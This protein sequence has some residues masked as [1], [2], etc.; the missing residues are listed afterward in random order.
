MGPRRRLNGWAVKTVFGLVFLN[1]VLV[2][3]F[4]SKTS[5][6]EGRE[7]SPATYTP[8]QQES[9]RAIK[10]ILLAGQVSTWLETPEP[11]YNIAITL[12]MKLERMGYQV[13][14]N[15]EQ[16][17]DAALVIDY[18]ETAGRQYEMFQQGT[19]ITCTVTLHHKAVGKVLTRK[20]EAATTW[21]QPVGSLYWDAVQHL[22]ENPHYYYLGELIKGWLTAQEGEVVVF[23][24]MLK[25]PPLVISTEGGGS[26]ITARFKANGNA[27][28]LAI[29]ELGRLKDPRG[30]EPLLHLLD[31]EV[32]A[33]RKA[34]AA[35]LGEMGDPAILDRLTQL[36]STEKDPGVRVAVDAAIVRLRQ[37]P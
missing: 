9:L 27:R 36:S 33:E 20:F 3:A 8:A 32:A 4:P 26:Q 10:T 12:K 23:S 2:P 6:A 18:R 35:A 25:E 24:R 30:I 21:P 14:L 5:A 11:L 17:F 7:A 19:N 29:R 34:A 28:L 15:P 16:P 31:Q 37:T 13:V 1:T 22:E